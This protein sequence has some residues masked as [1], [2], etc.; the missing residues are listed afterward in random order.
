M[1]KWE[2][3]VCGYVHVGDEP[4]EECPVCSADK[5]MFVEVVEEQ[6]A[7]ETTAATEAAPGPQPAVPPSL[8]AR[9]YALAVALTTRHH[10]HPIMVHTPNGIVPMALVFLLITAWFGWPLF[11]TAALYSLVFVLISMPLVICTGYVMWRQRYRGAFTPVFK[12]KI[13]ASITTLVLLLGLIIWRVVQPDIVTT[14]STGRWIYLGACLLLVGAI[15]IA[16]HLGGKLVFGSR[17]D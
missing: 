11:E 6:T 2:C 15:G 4:P 8:S 12:I 16:G 5:S 10:L 13:S 7:T 17:K 9:F 14:A 3:T 1:K